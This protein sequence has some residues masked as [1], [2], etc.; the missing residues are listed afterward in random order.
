MKYK[1][2]LVTIDAVEFNRV[3]KVLGF[4]EDYRL[5]DELKELCRNHDVIV[6]PD[7][8]IIPTLEGD[9]RAELG[10]FIIKGL[11]GEIYPCK[12]DVF[13]AKYEAV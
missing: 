11:K 8:L 4:T 9:M 13:H 1:A 12:P 10:D 7:Y 5:T 6:G 3:I 2:K